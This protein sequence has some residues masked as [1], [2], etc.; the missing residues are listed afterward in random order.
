MESP[1]FHIGSPW[2]QFDP[3][4]PGYL[5]RKLKN[6]EHVRRA[7]LI[8]VYKANKGMAWDGLLHDMLGAVLDG[9]FKEKPG[10]KEG[11]SL[12][13][14]HIFNAYVDLEADDIREDRLA[15]GY[16]RK[17]GDLSVMEEAYENTARIFKVTNG[18]RLANL[19]SSHKLRRHSVM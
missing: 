16:K 1:R 7:E 14:L 5:E 17:L 11:Y 12:A 19:L 4:S 9:T 15:S 10:P 3:E 6:G 13:M 18:R 8:T 2:H